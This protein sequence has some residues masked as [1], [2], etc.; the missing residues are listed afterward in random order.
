MRSSDEGHSCNGRD[1]ATF[2]VSCLSRS[3]WYAALQSLTQIGVYQPDER[4]HESVIWQ[5]T[6][7]TASTPVICMSPCL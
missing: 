2:V 5:A 1:G 6:T 3:S 4:Q 7:Q